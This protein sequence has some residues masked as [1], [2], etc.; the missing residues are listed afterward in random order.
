MI[1]LTFAV[2]VAQA[3]T[4]IT[5]AP[6]ANPATYGQPL[7]LTATVTPA[8]ATGRITFYDGVSII[9]TG[10]FAGGVATATTISLS[11]GPHSL[12]AYYGGDGT[13]EAA[14]PPAISLAVKAGE[15]QSFGAPQPLTVET[16]AAAN[17]AY[18]VTGDFNGDNRA[19]LIVLDPSLNNVVVML[20]DG[21]GSFA[22]AQ[23]YSSSA[24]PVS[25]AIGDWDG[26]GVQ[27][28]A[29]AYADSSVAIALGNGNGSFRFQPPMTFAAGASHIALA[30]A[31]FNRDGIADLAI[32]TPNSG[33]LIALGNGDGTFKTSVVTLLPD[34][35]VYVVADDFNGDG[36]A[37][38]LVTGVEGFGIYLGNGDG[39]FGPAAWNVTYSDVPAAAV[40]DFNNDGILDVATF[41]GIAQAPIQIFTG[42]GD[43]SFNI[44]I[45]VN[46]Y[47][48]T[49]YR[50]IAA[51]DVNGDG[52]PDILATRN[53]YSFDSPGQ[54]TFVV[55]WTGG[56]DGTFQQSAV[57]SGV[58]GDSSF[59]FA[60]VNGDT[61]LDFIDAGS[62][63]SGTI[64][65]VLGGAAPDLSISISNGTGFTSGRQDAHYWLTV[66]NSGS[67]TTIGDV[68]VTD[69]LPA[70]MNA[71]AISGTGWS[72]TLSALTCT[73]PDAL[74]AGAAFPPIVITVNPGSQAGSVTDNATVSGGGDGILANN[75]ATDTTNVRAP[76]TIT[77]SAAPNPSTLGQPVTLA[78]QVSNGTGKVAFYDGLSLVGVAAVSGTQ[79]TVSTVS[80]LPG[81]RSIIA[82]YEGDAD[83]GQTESVPYVQMVNPVPATG[84]SLNSPIGLGDTPMD[85]FVADL[86]QDGKLDAITIN[87][88]SISVLLGN[89]DGTMQPPVQ[90][91]VTATGG[92]INSGA[93]GDF[94]GDGIPDV[95]VA[96]NSSG[97]WVVD[98]LY[99]NPDGS[100]QPPVS[101][102]VSVVPTQFTSK[103]FAADFNADGV[104]DLMYLLNDSTANVLLGNGDGTFRPV[105]TSTGVPF[106]SASTTWAVSDLN[107]DGIPD[108]IG[109][110]LEYTNPG[111]WVLL[112][113]GDGTFATAIKY[114]GFYTSGS[115]QV[116]TGDFNGDGRP[117]VL[118]MDTGSTALVFL[119]N[120]D[121]TLGAP[122]L[123]TASGCRDALI[124]DFNGDGKL[125]FVCAGGTSGAIAYGN[126][127]GSFTKP[128]AILGLVNHAAA[129][130][131][132]NGD[133]RLDLISVDNADNAIGIWL[134]LSGGSQ[135]ARVN[136]VPLCRDGDSRVQTGVSTQLGPGSMADGQTRP[137]NPSSSGCG[138]PSL[139]RHSQ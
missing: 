58:P 138:V 97:G 68:T 15:S 132:L 7:I 99:G 88:S 104:A 83:N 102:A 46:G 95:A 26:D 121:G 32:V 47:A 107:G 29:V 92:A 134:G 93:I 61:I 81:T 135:P 84:L 13:N 50:T 109:S 35:P 128:T 110:A 85:A 45:Y 124:A 59:A 82:V 6:S 126:G 49:S 91:P 62:A 57:F 74:A 36:I 53:A 19:D 25:V 11:T 103:I 116:Y 90:Y 2:S 14:T 115:G 101:V 133:G 30:V 125:D 75:T 89:G 8:A 119:A 120:P 122:V 64:Q 10:T 114:T 76:I 78:A 52:Y 77:A 96:V 22:V 18:V 63:S 123:S 129:A 51:A 23:T 43:G 55:V 34:Y 60:D 136:S 3:A 130:G 56:G 4:T 44:P 37:D 1:I 117:D 79:A 66:T 65:L 139:P 70:V 28:L 98:I 137:F 71:T 48:P 20:G 108:L 5:L 9:A 73:R 113:A 118:L 131:D 27:D 80:L 16:A 72:C 38:L 12:T 41:T 69:L 24:G 54:N 17:A 111:L 87:L 86:N 31:D 39:T 94:N 33:L 100:L 21:Q 42:K 106:Y 112:G 40:A 67:A 105:Q 127:D